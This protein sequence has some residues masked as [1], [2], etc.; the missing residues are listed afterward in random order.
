MIKEVFM[1]PNGSI[2]HSGGDS[3]TVEHTK[4]NVFTTYLQALK[5]SGQVDQNTIVHANHTSLPITDWIEME[6]KDG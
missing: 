2:V 6:K 4:V 1:L 5:D 3:D